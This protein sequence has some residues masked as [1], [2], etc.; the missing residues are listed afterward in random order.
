MTHVT[1]RQGK[2]YRASIKL[3][4]LEQLA[5]NGMIE[6]KLRAAGFSDVSV[7]GKGA[8]RTAEAVWPNEDASAP[9]PS[10][11]SSLVEIA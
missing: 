2:R 11:V 10:Q 6:G 3:G 5:D 4:L 1:V 7:S 9:L 8:L